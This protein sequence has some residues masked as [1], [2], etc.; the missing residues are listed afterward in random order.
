MLSFVQ[1]WVKALILVW[2]LLNCFRSEQLV[3]HMSPQG[4]LS[5]QLLSAVPFFELVWFAQ[6]ESSLA[7]ELLA[8]A[9]SLVVAKEMVDF[10]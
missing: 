5:L 6:V 4:T 9:V 10:A 2:V 7:A 8:Q 1:V 3:H